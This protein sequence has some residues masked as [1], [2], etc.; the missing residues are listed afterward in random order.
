M[1]LLHPILQATSICV[2]LCAFLLGVQR[3]RSRHLKHQARF[4]WRVH[5]LAGKIAIGGLFVGVGLGMAMTR[6]TWEQSFMTMGH[7]VGGV[8]TLSVFLAGAVSGWFLDKKREKRFLLPAV[9]GSIR[10]P[11]SARRGT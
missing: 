11:F 2:A 6:Y 10:K 9:H 4:Q 1:L 5:V 8:A 7:G 3:F